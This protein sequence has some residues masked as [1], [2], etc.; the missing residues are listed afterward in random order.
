MMKNIYALILFFGALINVALNLML[1]PENNILTDY[2]ISG[3]NGAAFASM[4]SLSFWNLSMVF[5]VRKK[6]GFY[7]FYIPFI[8]R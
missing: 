7:S 1:I 6:F 2:G 4:C 3:M 5:V 8:K